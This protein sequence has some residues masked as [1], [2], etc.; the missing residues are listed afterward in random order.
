VLATVDPASARLGSPP[1]S[2][3]PADRL[4]FRDAESPSPQKLTA[5]EVK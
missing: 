1:E 3:S 4:G 5:A 2:A